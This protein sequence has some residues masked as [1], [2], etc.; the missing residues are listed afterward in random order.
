MTLTSSQVKNLIR[1]LVQEAHERE[2]EL[3][4]T[5]LA[6]LLYLIDVTHF[7]RHG[8]KLTGLRWVFLHYG[9]YA[10]EIPQILEQLHFDLP[11]DEVTTSAGRRAYVFRSP[12]P[13][14]IDIDQVFDASAARS[15]QRVLDQWLGADMNDL[16]SYVYFHTAPMKAAKRRGQE[17]DFSTIPEGLPDAL[18]G[19][20]RQLDP[21]TA[22]TLRERA[23]AVLKK[24]GTAPAQIGLYPLPRYDRL[25]GEAMKL[26]G[27]APLLPKEIEVSADEEALNGFGS[28]TQRQ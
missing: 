6:K 7:G 26:V 23:A 4:R 19:A 13:V 24:V 14:E 22:D 16:L 28:P 25:F 8:E 15:V 12:A 21:K 5:R 27:E 20:Q 3:G 11:Q 10:K 2:A 9:P 17:L 1:V 18:R